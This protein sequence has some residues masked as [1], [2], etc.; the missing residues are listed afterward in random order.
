M[1]VE[2]ANRDRDHNELVKLAKSSKYISAFSSIMFS[3]EDAY[4]KGWIRVARDE[5]GE[6]LGFTC[7]R[8][9]VR[10]PE[11]MLYFVMVDPAFEGSGVGQMLMAD[12]ERESPHERIALKVMNDNVR[13]IALYKKLGYIEAGPAYDG[14]GTVM[15]KELKR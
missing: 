6:L 1:R 13:A 3:S 2:A 7:V 4:R 10:T 9:K 8:H 15:V 11:T 14:E 5:C 12:L